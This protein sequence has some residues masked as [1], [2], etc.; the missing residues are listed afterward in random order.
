MITRTAWVGPEQTAKRKLAADLRPF[1]GLAR[2][3]HSFAER[4]LELRAKSPLD[5]PAQIQARLLLQGSNQLRLI[6][7]A[8]ERGYS[9]QALGSAAT[10]YEH[11][12]ALAYVDG[13]ATRAAEWF[14]HANFE[15]TY[16]SPKKRV[17]GIRQ[18]L[19]S[20]GVPPLEVERLVTS[21]EDH[22]TRFCAAKH[23]N[24]RL[25]RTYGIS[26]SAGNVIFH[27]GAVV[28]PVYT[29]LSRMALYHGSRLI[30]D[31]TV[32]FVAPAMTTPSSDAARFKQARRR[33]LMRINDLASVKTLDRRA[34]SGAP[35]ER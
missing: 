20:G 21:W 29:L 4:A 34:D 35:N 24:P 25:L 1:L 30:A 33:I 10:L 9:L 17:A 28:G 6:E 13:N 19:K 16:P 15:W 12:S 18:M 3:A 26:A 8:A 11:I 23:G 32:L 2:L 14:A 22:H 31:G 27:V 7:L 5:R